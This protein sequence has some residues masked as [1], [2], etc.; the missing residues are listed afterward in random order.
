MREKKKNNKFL[1]VIDNLWAIDLDFWEN[2]R[3]PLLAAEDGSTILITTRDE[4]TYKRMPDVRL[5]EIN[6]KGIDEENCWKL[7]QSL[8]IPQ[9]II[10]QDLVPIGK[11][12]ASRCHG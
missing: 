9:G 10:N 12:I 1:L 4:R 5:L 7:I 3:V 11:Q 2:L 8:A 6:L